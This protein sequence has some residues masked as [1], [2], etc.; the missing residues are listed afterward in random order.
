MVGD[1]DSGVASQV[2]ANGATFNDVMT[3]VVE[4]APTFYQLR[5]G[6]RM[7]AYDWYLQ[8]LITRPEKHDIT[9]CVLSR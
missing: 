7:T 6:V 2:L 8:G 1:C 4:E 5:R 9:L 3:Q